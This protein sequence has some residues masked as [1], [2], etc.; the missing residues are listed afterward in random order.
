M[1]TRYH[2]YH[3]D[4]FSGIQMKH[5]TGLQLWSEQDSPEFWS[6]ID[7]WGLFGPREQILQRNLSLREAMRI[8]LVMVRGRY[9]RPIRP[10]LG[11][12]P[13]D[14]LGYVKPPVK[15]FLGIIP[16]PDRSPEAAFVNVV[17]PNGFPQQKAQAEP[18]DNQEQQDTQGTSNSPLHADPDTLRGGRAS[19]SSRSGALRK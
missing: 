7:V 19:K 3:I 5:Q 16:Y 15:W 11:T 6:I 9:E 14:L 17:G 4:V 10:V 8:S 18:T 13:Y 12:A 2:H 1:S